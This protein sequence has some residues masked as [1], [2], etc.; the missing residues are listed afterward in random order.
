MNGYSKV[1]D[2]ARVVRSMRV[3]VAK[4][5]ARWWLVFVVSESNIAVAPSCGDVSWL[6]H[7]AA[8]RILFLSQA[9]AAVVKS[10]S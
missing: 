2:L 1:P 5:Q 6:E 8:T 3:N 10:D 4:L 9:C 7:V